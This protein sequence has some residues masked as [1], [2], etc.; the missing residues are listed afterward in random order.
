MNTR[1][2]RGYKKASSTFPQPEFFTFAMPP[3]AANPRA[4]PQLAR[5]F[6]LR[7]SKRIN[8]KPEHRCGLKEFQKCSECTRKNKSCDKE[9]VSSR[10]Y[11]LGSLTVSIDS[12][13]LLSR[14]Q[15]LAGSCCGP[16]RG[17]GSSFRRGGAGNSPAFVHPACR[18]LHSPSGE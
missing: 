7:C 1:H 15:P 6:C 17:A 2:P 11:T 14:G 12:E 18:A 13:A 5:K 4:L 3:K 8:D 16:P 9:C 10:L